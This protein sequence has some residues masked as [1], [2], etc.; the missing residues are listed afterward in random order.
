MDCLS[1]RALLFSLKYLTTSHQVE[2]E[3]LNGRPLLWEQWGETHDTVT[4]Q[5]RSHAK[6][7][8]RTVLLTVKWP[9]LARAESLFPLQKLDQLTPCPRA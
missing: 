8:E 1:G 7:A 4:K 9:A 5:F 3:K 2:V 6:G